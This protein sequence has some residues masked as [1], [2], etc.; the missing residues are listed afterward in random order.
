MGSSRLYKSLLIRVAEA[1]DAT[2][3][4]V[5]DVVDGERR[6]FTS[7]GAFLHHA[8]LHYAEAHEAEPHEAEV[9]QAET[10]KTDETHKTE[11]P[12]AETPSTLATVPSPS[13]IPDAPSHRAKNDDQGG[14][15]E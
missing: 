8:E 10:H 12:E 1:R 13:A 14:H 2:H 15:H 11:T 6:D 5:Q 9:H 3:I 7:W 4:T